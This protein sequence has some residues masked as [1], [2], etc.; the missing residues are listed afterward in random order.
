[1]A[2]PDKPR[3]FESQ[4]FAALCQDDRGMQCSIAAIVKNFIKTTARFGFDEQLA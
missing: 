2:L 3:A 1:M 4:Y